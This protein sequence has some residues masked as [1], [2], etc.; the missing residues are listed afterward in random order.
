MML[1]WLEPAA[2]DCVQLSGLQRQDSTPPVSRNSFLLEVIPL[3]L[4][5]ASMLPLGSEYNIRWT[6][7]LWFANQYAACTRTTGDGTCTIQ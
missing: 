3:L 6:L 5:V 4:K 7:Y 2:R 1:S